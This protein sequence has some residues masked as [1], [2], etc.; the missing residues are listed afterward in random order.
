MTNSLSAKKSIRP[1]DI[2][3]VGGSE[4]SSVTRP[5]TATR[6]KVQPQSSKHS[7]NMLRFPSEVAQNGQ[8]HYINFKI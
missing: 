7:V 4:Y 8:G 3:V 2:D 5:T 1:T 6:K